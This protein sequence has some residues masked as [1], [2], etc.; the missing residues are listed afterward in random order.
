MIRQECREGLAWWAQGPIEVIEQGGLVHGGSNP[1]V[2]ELQA[3]VF[4]FIDY[5]NRTMAKPFK[6]TYQGKALTA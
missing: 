3:R 2:E 6:W 1:S 5:Y 4:S